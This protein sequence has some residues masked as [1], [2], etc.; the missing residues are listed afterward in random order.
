MSYHLFERTQRA[1][2]RRSDLMQ[3]FGM[4]TGFSEVQTEELLDLVSAHIEYREAQRDE[5]RGYTDQEQRWR[6]QA[7]ARSDF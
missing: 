6:D 3:G 7:C 1:S 2:R 4:L 5:Q